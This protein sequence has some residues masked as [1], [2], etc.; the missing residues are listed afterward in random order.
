[1]RWTLQY[2]WLTLKH[3]VFVFRAGLLTR[4]PIWRLVIHDWSKFTPS[5]A[6]HYG[7]QFFGDK[8]DPLGFSYAWLY[9]QRRNPHHWEFWIPVTGHTSGGYPD[10]SPMPMP[11]WAVREMIADWMG[12]SRAY[13]G[14]WPESLLGWEW[15][16][17]NWYGIARRMHPQ[18]I[19]TVERV[20]DEVF[21]S[22]DWE[23][24]GECLACAGDGMARHGNSIA[25]PI[26]YEVDCPIC[27]RVGRVTRPKQAAQA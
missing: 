17:K 7:R 10:L 2:L 27:Q 1:M 23:P 5:E 14:K 12:A 21:P 19:K 24:W 3:K 20:M 15:F 9:H 18:T 11:E 16:T 13:S 4:A 26:C 8:G 22:A 6:R 25:G